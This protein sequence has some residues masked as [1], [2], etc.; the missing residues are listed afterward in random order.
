MAEVVYCVVQDGTNK[1]VQG[2]RTREQAERLAEEL[3]SDERRTIGTR[4][5]VPEYSVKVD[6]DDQAYMNKIWQEHKTHTR[7]TVPGR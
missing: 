7:V 2:I 3:A 6:Q 4:I 1:I 5:R